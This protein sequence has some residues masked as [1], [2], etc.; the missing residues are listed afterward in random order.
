[1][2]LES[3]QI[4]TRTHAHTRFDDTGTLEGERTLHRSIGETSGLNLKMT[5][6]S[7]NQLRNLYSPGFTTKAASMQKCA[8]GKRRTIA[9]N[10]GSPRVIGHCDQSPTEPEPRALRAAPRLINSLPRVAG[11]SGTSG[12]EKKAQF[13]PLRVSLQSKLRRNKVKGEDSLV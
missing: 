12:K 10:A 2:R 1:M 11:I 13:F 5:S 8:C 7:P 4:C 6:T 3:H 9:S